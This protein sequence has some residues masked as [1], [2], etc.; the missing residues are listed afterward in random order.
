MAD[1][2]GLDRDRDPC[3]KAARYGKLGDPPAWPRCGT[4]GQFRNEKVAEMARADV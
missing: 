3:P 1:A 2:N 4:V